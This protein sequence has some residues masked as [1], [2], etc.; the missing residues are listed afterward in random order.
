VPK[1]E[2]KLS[3]KIRNRSELPLCEE[4]S[5]L[6]DEFKRGVSV[7]VDRNE[8]LV[9]QP[10]ARVARKMDEKSPS[11]ESELEV[12][13]VSAQTLR[14]FLEKSDRKSLWNGQRNRNAE[15]KSVKI[16]QIWNY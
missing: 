15:L 9:D 16:N 12:E 8:F 6:D 10:L 13:E 5:R 1:S 2:R 14:K 7:C 11:R 4:S 3:K